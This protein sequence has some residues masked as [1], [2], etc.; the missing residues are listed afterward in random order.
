M[1]H[2]FFL[3]GWRLPLLAG[4]LLV[5]SL[6]RPGQA[7]AQTIPDSTATSA[8]AADTTAAPIVAPS[9]SGASGLPSSEFETYNVSGSGVRYTAALTGIYSTGTVE[10][11]YLTTSHTAN[12]ALGKHWLLPAAFNFSYGKQDGLLRERELLG[13]FTPAYQ[14]G[15]LKYY[16]LAEGGQSNLRA[17]AR[18]LVGG[19]GVGYQFYHDSLQNEVTLSQFF[20]YEHT[21]YLEGLLRQVPRGS[22]RLKLR[23]GKG[24]VV[25]TTLAFYQPSLQDFNGDY[26]INSTSSLSF[27][28]SRHLALTASYAYSY[29]SV[30]VE[31]RSPLNTNLTVGFTYTTGK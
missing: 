6:A 4:S 22:T 24:P 23:F 28:V 30:A 14:V 17:I 26:R 25:F 20:L 29:E 15:R 5:A 9:G 2:F 21:Q 1:S 18:R 31:N 10:R 12:L 8:P 3:S 16:A 19:V 7:G 11:I 27:G 13:L